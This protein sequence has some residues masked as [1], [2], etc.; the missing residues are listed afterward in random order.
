[1]QPTIIGTI[2]TV[3]DIILVLEGVYRNVLPLITKRIEK[4]LV[5]SGHVYVY[6]S[7]S[8]IIRWT[9]GLKW[10]PSRISS[11]YLIYKHQESNLRKKT[12]SISYKQ[13]KWHIV[14]YFDDKLFQAPSDLFQ[15]P[16]EEYSICP[17]IK[18]PLKKVKIDQVEYNAYKY[19]YGLESEYKYDYRLDL[20][21]DNAHLP[22]IS[23]LLSS[24]PTSYLI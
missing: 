23:G 24:F 7:N 13:I 11:I 2:Q 20:E 12:V 17:V 14:I 3:H 1:M 19:E 18:K 9:D 16:V 4:A 5:D 6:K 15:F 8:G 10:S 21:L 22:S